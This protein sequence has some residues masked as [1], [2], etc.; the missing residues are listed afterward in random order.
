MTA[1][2]H[3]NGFGKEEQRNAAV[4][5]HRASVNRHTYRVTL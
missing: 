4:H 5:R 2:L 3:P 1:R